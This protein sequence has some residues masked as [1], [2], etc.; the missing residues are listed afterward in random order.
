MVKEMPNS[1]FGIQPK[2]N[3]SRNV[4]RNAVFGFI[5]RFFSLIV[6]F[7]IRT[8]VIYRFGAEYLGMN[9]LFASVLRVLNLADFGF[10]TAIVYSL[11]RPVAEGDTATVCA[12][13]GTY[14]KIYRII[15]ITILCCG[16]LAMPLLP[17]LVKDTSI[18]GNMN[19]YIWYS[20]FLVDSSISYLL[21]G[22][23]TAIPSALQRNDILSRIDTI[24]LL[25]KTTIQ[26]A[27][28]FLTKNFYFYLVTSLVFTIIRNLLISW[29]INLL[30]PQY[31]CRGSISKQQIEELK[32]K[33]YGILIAKLRWVSRNGIDSICITS[34][35]GLTMAA[36][37]GNYL[38]IHS[39]VVSLSMV[40]C[41]SMMASVG[42]SIAIESRDKNYTDM[43]RFNFMYMLLTGWASICLLCL[44]QPF[45]RLWVGE[46]LMLRFPEVVAL[47]AYFYILKMGDMRW[48]YFEGAGLWW[49]A[50]FI[51]LTETLANI[52]LNILLAK[53]L[54][55][56]GIILATLI[57]LFFIDFIFSARILFQQYYCNGKLG[58]FFYDHSRYFFITVLIAVPCIYVCDMVTLPMSDMLAAKI[59]AGSAKTIFGGVMLA[60]RLLIC[61]VFS[62]SGFSIFYYRTVQFKDAKAWLLK[63]YRITK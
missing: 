43:R 20:I 32:P 25:C 57:S 17:H 2:Y 27:F 47:T 9:S 13:L 54:G 45:V 46:Q 28:L 49:Q 6:P 37:Y 16:I 55:V 33:V 61:T 44:Y 48:I 18:P 35:L 42:N 53:Y 60:V 26:A 36:I 40:V 23:K 59:T 39:A 10:G 62:A 5:N 3:R 19:L 34:F 56:L 29:S 7:I 1:E 51:A 4:K 12:Y 15:G 8:I 11:Y 50:R 14:K 31:Q 38:S 58:E 52:C 21:Y 24:V 63:R 41:T 22:Y 30:Y